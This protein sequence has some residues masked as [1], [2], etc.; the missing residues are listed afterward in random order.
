MTNSA[1]K[2]DVRIEGP[3]MRV[4]PSAG[5]DVRVSNDGELNTAS[6]MP[7]RNKNFETQQY[8]T[9]EMTTILFQKDELWL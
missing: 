7:T 1:A 2:P 3:I 6:S 8:T 9:D 5:V 4:L